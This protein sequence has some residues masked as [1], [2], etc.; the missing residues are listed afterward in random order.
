[1]DLKNSFLGGILFL[2]LFII[3]YFCFFYNKKTDETTTVSS[4]TDST[5][6][7]A[8]TDSTSIPT[9][10]D[11]VPSV[12]S[13]PSV[14][15]APS[16]PS[17]PTAPAIPAVVPVLNDLDK[18]TCDTWY[19]YNNAIVNNNVDI[20]KYNKTVTTDGIEYDKINC[21]YGRIGDKSSTCSTFKFLGSHE[22]WTSCLNAAKKDI[23]YN[24]FKT[25]TWTDNGN[26]YWTHLCYGVVDD[27]VH[28]E[29]GNTKCLIKN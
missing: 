2:V 3:I 23:D 1:M 13:V 8:S 4:T 19:K 20:T 5:S 14:Q 12:P 29:D 11:S 27:Y 9:S 28:A 6:I 24:K 25:V 21:V 18:K 10:T 15:S 7:P 26:W 22:N 17:V 16:V